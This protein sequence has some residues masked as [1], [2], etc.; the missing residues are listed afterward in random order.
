[1]AQ[2]SFTAF[3]DATAAVSKADTPKSWTTPWSNADLNSRCGHHGELLDGE[4][5]NDVVLTR[6]AD[7][8]ESHSGY[9]SAVADHGRREKSLESRSTCC[10]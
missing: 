3:G 2:R 10:P 6:L 8:H 5:M 4:M 1:M 7:F 9:G